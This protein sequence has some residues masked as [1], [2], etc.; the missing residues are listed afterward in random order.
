MSWGL[1]MIDAKTIGL[2]AVFLGIFGYSLKDGRI[3]DGARLAS[4]AKEYKLTAQETSALDVCMSDMVGK[5]ITFS[6]STGSSKH[7]SVPVNI[8]AC[9]AKTMVSVFEDGKYASHQNVVDF[10]VN[11]S[12]EKTLNSPDLKSHTRSVAVQ[13]DRLTASLDQCAERY[14]AEE[15]KRAQEFIKEYK[16]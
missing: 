11:G 4:L 12:G 2:L 7:G 16:P 14:Q 9:Q 6:S 15:S 3:D 5:S 1:N 13:F 10:M 8:C